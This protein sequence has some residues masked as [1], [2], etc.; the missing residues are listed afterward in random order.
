MTRKDLQDLGLEK[1]QINTIMDLHGRD[2]ERSKSDYEALKKESEQLK[3]QLSERDTDIA[4]LTKKATGNE[5][6]TKNYTELQEKYKST[7]KEYEQSLY[8]FK[9]N[10]AID[11]ELTNKYKAKNLKAV[12]AVLDLNDVTYDD[13]KGLIGL[14]KVVEP[15]LKENGFLFG[16]SESGTKKLLFTTENNVYDNDNNMNKTESFKSEFEKAL[17]LDNNKE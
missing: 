10:N 5:E 9:K 16:V 3:T 13:E 6:L 7:K 11:N 12:K 1:D 8:D 2:I 14:D 17:G 15:S 4:E